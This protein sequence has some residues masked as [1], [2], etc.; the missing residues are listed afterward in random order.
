MR[1]VNDTEKKDRSGAFVPGGAN[2]PSGGS[3][4]GGG[5][6]APQ[7]GL[8]GALQD[9]LAKRK[10]KVSG[11]GMYYSYSFPKAESV[12][13]QFQMTRKTTMTNGERLVLTSERLFRSRE[14]LPSSV[15]YLDVNR[16]LP[17]PIVQASLVPIVDSICP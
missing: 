1:R 6:G 15:L 4:S 10:Q 16:E 8:A 11:S 9:A 5:G 13:I 2:E 7:G 12:L 3:S 14:H 17:I